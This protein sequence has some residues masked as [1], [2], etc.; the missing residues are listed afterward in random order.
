M[1]PIDQENNI[2]IS[3]KDVS[4][5]E[6]QKLAMKDPLIECLI[7]LAQEQGRTISTSALLAGF[8]LPQDGSIGPDLFMRAAQRLNLSAQ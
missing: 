4:D 6:R 7:L 2:K 1:M 8:P 3:I 5:L